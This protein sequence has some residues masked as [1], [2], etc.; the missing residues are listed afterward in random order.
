MSDTTHY[1]NGTGANRT[2]HD[3]FVVSP[4]VLDAATAAADDQHITLGTFAGDV[5]QYD[6][7]EQPDHS[8]HSRKATAA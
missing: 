7:S 6:R 8:A 3:F 1:R 2:R 4:Q 5:F